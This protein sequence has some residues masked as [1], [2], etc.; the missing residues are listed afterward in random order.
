MHAAGNSAESLPGLPTQKW[1]S[2]TR[3][4][5]HSRTGGSSILCVV[6]YLQKYSAA[7]CESS[8][9]V[10]RCVQKSCPAVVFSCD[11]SRSELARGSHSNIFV[12]RSSDRDRRSVNQH[13]G[14]CSVLRASSIKSQGSAT[15]TYLNQNE[16]FS[17]LFALA[18][19]QAKVLLRKASLRRTESL[20]KRT[21]AKQE[22][23]GLQ[24][25]TDDGL[26]TTSLGPEFQHGDTMARHEKTMKPIDI[27]YVTGSDAE[28]HAGVLNTA[29][30][31]AEAFALEHPKPDNV[32]RKGML[33]KRIV[34]K[35]IYWAP[36]HVTLTRDRCIGT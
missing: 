12:V 15:S 32:L 30:T 33:K 7:N 20:D 11:N 23:G 2:G 18:N 1:H 13:A 34:S 26:E 9:K 22:A 29:F 6:V 36:R 4:G 17:D 5:S 16:R 28:M 24:I 8:Q 14:G 10:L 25:R 31:S 21:Q 19:R 3:T 27:G 35:R